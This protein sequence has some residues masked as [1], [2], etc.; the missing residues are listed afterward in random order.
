[1]NL[2]PT[3]E[4]VNFML[5]RDAFSQWLGLEIEELKPGFCKLKMR[6]RAEMLNGFGIAHGGICFSL[7]DSCL[8]FAANSRGNLS[9]TLKA[10]ISWPK[11]A[12]DGDILVAECKE[13][14]LS[15]KSGTYDVEIWNQLDN[16]IIALFRGM[17]HRT[18]KPVVQN[19]SPT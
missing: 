9:L 16:Q 18:G 5:E 6:V 13:I 2:D 14:Y 15:E 3:L 8:A 19:L 1:M 4:N 10:D 12:R 7:A 17:V 11:P